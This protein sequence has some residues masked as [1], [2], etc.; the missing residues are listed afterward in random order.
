MSPSPSTTQNRPLTIEKHDNGFVLK[1]I[2]EKF[3]SIAE[4]PLPDTAQSG[5]PP[6]CTPDGAIYYCAGNEIICIKG[7][8]VQ[9]RYEISNV[10]GNCFLTAL[11]GNSLVAAVNNRLVHLSAEGK[12]LTEIVNPFVCTCRPAIDETGRIFIGG[13]DAIVCFY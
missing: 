5:Q 9:W 11:K 3:E 6:V 13:T 12:L 2:G 10:R 1:I 8:A 4:F 7:N